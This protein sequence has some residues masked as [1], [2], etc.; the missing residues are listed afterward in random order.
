MFQ[1]S[2]WAATLSSFFTGLALLIRE[3]RRRE[4]KPSKM[5]VKWRARG[6]SWSCHLDFQREPQQD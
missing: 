1:V 5:R 2:A 4:D 3:V 6:A